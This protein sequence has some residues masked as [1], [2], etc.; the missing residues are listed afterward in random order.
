MPDFADAPEGIF[1]VGSF[2]TIMAPK[3]RKRARIADAGA[4]VASSSAAT[5][6]GDIAADSAVA[7]SINAVPPLQKSVCQC[8]EI[9]FQVRHGVAA[10]G[11]SPLAASMPV[12]DSCETMSVTSG[13]PSAVSEGA[14]F[15]PEV[16]DVGH[17]PFPIGAGGTFISIVQRAQNDKEWFLG[18]S[19][20]LLH[21]AGLLLANDPEE[22]KSEFLTSQGER[23]LHWVLFACVGVTHCC[24]DNASHM[25]RT[26]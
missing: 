3:P 25:A 6:A 5:V 21:A 23:R 1:H 24:M 15:L 2:L 13:T 16:D 17:Y 8:V 12:D 22:L 18:E 14:A 7:G 19:A 11:P 10:T 9:M 20:A 26:T 4:T